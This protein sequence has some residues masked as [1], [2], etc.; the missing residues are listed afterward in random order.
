MSLKTEVLKILEQNTNTYLSGQDLAKSFDVSRNAVWKAINQLKEDGYII[1]SIQNRGYCLSFESDVISEE[2]IY[3]SLSENAKKLKIFFHK[4]LDSTNNEAKR[5]IANGFRDI[6]LII[7]NEQ[8]G[9]RGRLG[10]SFYSPKNTGI[11]M[12]FIFHPDL[13]LSDAVSVTTATSVAVVRAIEKL[14]NLKPQI[15]W[16]NDIYINNK[17]ACGI[18]TEAVMS[19]EVGSAHSIVIGIGINTTTISFPTEIETIA[20]S[21]NCNDLSRNRLISAIADE[22]IEICT[23][24]TDKSYIKEYREHSMIIGKNIDFYKNN[25]KYNGVAVD[26]DNNGGLIVRLPDGNIEKLQSG[27]VTVRLSK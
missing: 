26:V 11:Y 12:S 8:T 16:V 19:F 18:L 27:E 9:G 20:T 17:K 21:L 14:T 6:A 5:M 2:T 10:R 7:A 24:L 22:M 3:N 4:T 15:K 23:D 1:H 13:D 25:I